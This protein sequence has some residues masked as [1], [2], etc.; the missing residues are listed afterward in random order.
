MSVPLSIVKYIRSLWMA[1]MITTYLHV[2]TDGRLQAWGGYPRHYGFNDLREGS[3]ISEQIPLLEGM[4]PVP[5][6][7]VLEF[8]GMENGRCAHVHLI[9]F[10]DGTWVL[11]FDATAEHDRQ[12]KIQQQY[13]ELSI[14]TYRQN[15]ML[16]E[17]EQTRQALQEEKRHLEEAG[18]LKTEFIASLSHELRTPL[19]SI[20]GYTKLLDEAKK[21]DEQ[22]VNYLGTV[23]ENANHL[24]ALIDNVLDEAKLE[25]GKIE[26]NPVNC[27]PQALFAGIHRLFVPQAREKNLQLAVEIDAAMPQEIR[28]DELRLRQIVINLL[29]NALK[30]TKEGFVKLSAHW[31]DERLFFSVQDSGPGISPDA[32]KKIFSAYHR[33]KSTQELPGAGLGLAI[34]HRLLEMMGGSMQV[35]SE[36][37]QGAEFSASIR[38]PHGKQS[39]VT[40]NAPHSAPA[41]L[42]AE[43]T[44]SIRLLMNL[45]L[46]EGGYQIHQATNGQEAINLALE[47]QPSLIL[48]DMQMPI[49]DGYAA[50][51]KLR[52]QGFAQPIIALSASDFPEDKRDALEAGC[53]VYLVKPVGMQQLLDT[54]AD[55]TQ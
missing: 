12:Q 28:V 16:Q 53:D 40:A 39:R 33:E 2:D 29:T 31:Q 13:N 4:L 54:I 43:D 23:K 18:K 35:H 15:Q 7:Q 11:L 38:A 3:F 36:L 17:L 42:L 47:K 6:T 44:T 41:I 49:V 27:D 34:S 26:L 9:P 10:Y 45:Y 21:A 22:Q 46:E 37:G 51:Q 32:Q 50:V 24:L 14:L 19:T 20:I 48:M 30:F 8:V 25:T 52:E 5:H 55:F 1:E